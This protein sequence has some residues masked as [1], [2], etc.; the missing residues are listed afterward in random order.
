MDVLP[1]LAA[2]GIGSV[3]FLDTREA[4]GLILQYL[5]EIPFWPQMVKLGF[6]EDMVPQGA[7]GLPGFE[8]DLENKTVRLAPDLDQSTILTQF[9]ELALSGDLQPFAL[10]PEEAAGFFALLDAIQTQAASSPPFLKGQVVGPV[11]FA[12]MVKGH[13]GKAILFDRELSQAVT[14]GL[15]LKAAW[16]AQQL[17]HQG[18]QAIVFFDEPYLSGFGSA[19]M[20]ISREEVIATVTEALDIGREA[21]EVLFGL[22]C[23]G[24]TD[25]A[26][27]LETPI[28]ILS[29]DAYGFFDTLILYEQALKKFLARGG[30]LAWG[31]VPTTPTA[32]PET[33]DLLWARFQE[34]VNRLEK[35]G[36]ARAQ[37][38]SQSILTPA[39]GLGYLTPEQARD[40]LASLAEL[41][42]RGRDW[43]ERG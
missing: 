23:C 18:K 24:N 6:R 4:V 41:S 9:Y 36:L 3:P 19:F 12:G 5:P 14:R 31:L 43:L 21:G 15:A 42:A 7:G 17:R 40:A 30:C 29:F 13:D 34:Q 20:P 10:H 28:D 33:V 11:T 38:L 22:H 27:L 1:A 16:Q 25:W 8:L 2:T 37:L 26:M 39:C 32:T 35:L